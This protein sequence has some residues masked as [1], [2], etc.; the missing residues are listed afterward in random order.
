MLLSKEVIEHLLSYKPDFAT[1]V[2]LMGNHEEVFLKVLSGSESALASCFE[3]GGRACV[4][5]YGVKTWEK[6]S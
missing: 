3:F 6:S 2:F 4:R 5:S 1:P